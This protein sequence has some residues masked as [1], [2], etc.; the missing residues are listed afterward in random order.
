MPETRANVDVSIVVPLYNAEPYLESWLSGVL[1]HGMAGDRVEIL[2]VDNNSTDRGPER[3]RGDPR[4]QLL[5]ESRRGAYAARNRGAMAARGRVLVFLD[6]D[7]VPQP[8]WLS[9]LL[10]QMEDDAVQVVV[11]RVDPGGDSYALRLLGGYENQK[12]RFAFDSAM[13]ALYS[14]Y[15]GNMA[16]RR[17]VFEQLGRFN[18][19]VRGGD[20]RFVVKAVEQLG[21][22]AVRYAPAARVLHLEVMTLGSFYRKFFIYGRSRPRLADGGV[23]RSLSG[24]ERAAIV[25]QAASEADSPMVARAWLLALLTAGVGAFRAGA[26][27]GRWRNAR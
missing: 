11:G 1:A 23:Q 27:M 17:E 5:S 12:M 14:G 24:S 22:D 9:E 7:C 13:P 19:E 10:K 16:V 15:G 4:I 20:T 6:P 26:A 3:L 21:G 2:V 25:R 8:G 18:E